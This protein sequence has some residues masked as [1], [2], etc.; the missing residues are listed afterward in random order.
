MKK[1]KIG[2]RL[3]T[4]YKDAI[5]KPVFVT[6]DKREVGKIIEYNEE[7]GEG[8]IEINQ[9][10]WEKVAIPR[11]IDYQIFSTDDGSA[12]ETNTLN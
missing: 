10:D 2:V 6:P 12:S 5:G 7:T 1:I 9:Q 11:L 8:T 4:G 3:M